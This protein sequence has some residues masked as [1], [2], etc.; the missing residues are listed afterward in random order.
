MRKATES[1]ISRPGTSL[2]AMRV[3]MAIGEVSGKRESPFM[4]SELTSPLVMALVETT[5]PATKMIWMSITTDERSSI[6]ETVEAMAPKRK[7]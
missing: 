2:I 7:E 4:S 6:L 1:R 5:K 3:N